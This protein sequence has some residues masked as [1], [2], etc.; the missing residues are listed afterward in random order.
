MSGPAAVA[1]EGPKGYDEF[2]GSL[3][4]RL[5]WNQERESRN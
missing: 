4:E 3:R 5:L 2:D 1:R